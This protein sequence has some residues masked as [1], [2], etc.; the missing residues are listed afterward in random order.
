MSAFQK[1][2][3]KTLTLE[4]ANPFA[5]ERWH[6]TAMQSIAAAE[7]RSRENSAAAETRWSAACGRAWASRSRPASRSPPF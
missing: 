7:R 2:L 6:A 1:A 4:N 3:L 5:E